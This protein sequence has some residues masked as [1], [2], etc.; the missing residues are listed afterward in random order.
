[1]KRLKRAAKDSEGR[2]G[3]DAALSMRSVLQGPRRGGV[4]FDGTGSARLAQ[5]QQPAASGAWLGEL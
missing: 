3:N 2:I 1:M 5:A 4:S